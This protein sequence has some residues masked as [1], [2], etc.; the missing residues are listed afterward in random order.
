LGIYALATIF[1]LALQIG[2]SIALWMIIYMLEYFYA[3][4]LNLIQH[5]LVDR[6][7]IKVGSFVRLILVGFGFL[8]LL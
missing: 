7:L 1:I 6:K 5:G 8:Q 3:A 4:G 2:W